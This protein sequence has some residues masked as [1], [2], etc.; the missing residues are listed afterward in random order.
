MPSVFV[1]LYLVG[2]LIVSASLLRVLTTSLSLYFV[3]FSQNSFA[4]F[5]FLVF[6]CLD[7]TSKEKI[8]ATKPICFY[9]S[10]ITIGFMLGPDSVL[11]EAIGFDKSN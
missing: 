5:A 11:D 10:I 7:P 9:W 4:V 1:S 3:V 8:S 6:P 2:C